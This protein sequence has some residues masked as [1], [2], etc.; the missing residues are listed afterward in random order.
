MSG[1]GVPT[2]EAGCSTVGARL[3]SAPA[4][5]GGNPSPTVKYERWGKSGLFNEILTVVYS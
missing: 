2:V 3:T 5:V 1:S 4:M